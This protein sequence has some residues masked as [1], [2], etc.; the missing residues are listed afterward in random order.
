MD[1]KPKLLVLECWGLGDLAMATGFLHEAVKVWDVELVGKAYARTLLEPTFPQITY[2]VF[3]PPWSVFHGKYRLW[4]WDWL[5][6]F[7]LLWRLRSRHFDAAVSVRF[8]PRDHFVMWLAGAARRFGFPTKGSGILLNRPVAASPVE[9]HRVE[10]WRALGE[11]MGLPAMATADPMLPRAAYRSELGDRLFGKISKPIICLH[12]GARIALRRWPE[13]YFIEIVRRLRETFDFHLALVSEVDGYGAGLI[14]FAD[15]V[16]PPLQL[17][18]LVD[19]LGRADVVLCNDSGPAHLAAA[20]GR[21]VI[22]MMGPAPMGLIG[23]WGKW[24]KGVIRDICVWRP[25]ADQC[26]YSEPYCLT[27]LVPDLAW[28]DIHAYLLSLIAQGVLPPSLLKS[29]ISSS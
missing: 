16:V 9:R 24:T 18:E 27:K 4:K 12:P 25:C 13:S 11:A 21:V 6:I 1:R 29:G 17:R 5:G 22:A 26:R 3:D 7:S 8:D 23:P 2:T 20:T 19:V 15:T 10:D 28:S 14:P